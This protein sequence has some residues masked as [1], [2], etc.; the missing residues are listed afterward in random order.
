L[1]LAIGLSY[2]TFIMLKYIPSISTLFR[3]FILKDNKRY[4]RLFCAN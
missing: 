4:Q 2:V 3:V 1:M